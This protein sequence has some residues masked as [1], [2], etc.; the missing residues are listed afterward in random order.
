MEAVGAETGVHIL[1]PACGEVRPAKNTLVKVRERLGFQ[2]DVA[3][4]NT[5]CLV[6]RYNFNFINI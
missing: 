2:S 3:K 1:S 4:V 6:L 5:S